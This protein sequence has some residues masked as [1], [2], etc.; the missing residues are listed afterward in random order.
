M[1]YTSPENST[2]KPSGCQ[3]S[4]P[5]ESTAVALSI[6]YS[7]VLVL[8]VTGNS[9]VIN[10][11]RTNS[12]MK[13]NVF[14]YFL[15]CMASADIIDVLTVAPIH[16]IFFFFGNKWIGGTIGTI[17]CKLIYFSVE[18]S[19][20]VSVLTL[21]AITTDRYFAVCYMT[22]KPLS[23][24]K[25][26]VIIAGIWLASCLLASPQLYKFK[27]AEFSGQAYCFSSWTNDPVKELLG[28]QL[29]MVSKFALSYGI[30]LVL[31]IIMYAI[32]IR[33]LR[34]RLHTC[35]TEQNESLQRRIERQNR[36]LVEMFITLVIIFAICWFPVHVNH[37]LIAF[38]YQTYLCLPSI[39]PLLFYLLA[40]ANAVINPLLYFIFI[41]AFRNELK[42]NVKRLCGWPSKNRRQRGRFTTFSRLTTFFKSRSTTLDHNLDPTDQTYQT[43]PK[44]RSTESPNIDTIATG[45]TNEAIT[46]E[47]EIDIHKKPST[48]R[49]LQFERGLGRRR[50]FSFES[51]PTSPR[52]LTLSSHVNKAFEKD[53]SRGDFKSASLPWKFN[54]FV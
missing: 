29:E 48:I 20:L 27:V 2:R 46:T 21:V 28:S 17:T 50:R 30:P 13:S 36:P 3:S 53:L 22:Y 12:R 24:V 35:V 4:P 52:R 37:M 26:L 51:G 41:N 6:S 5:D 23:R 8:A 1:N 10:Y 33:E 16:W 14:N 25:T 32:I 15:I 34:K 47:A 39:V 40:H 44:F 11:A 9:L 54:T 43:S 42:R 45:Q 49:P 38:D 31:M 18:V 19:I 7:L